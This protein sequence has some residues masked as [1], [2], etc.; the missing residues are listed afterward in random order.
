MGEQ[1]APGTGAR[2]RHIAN[3]YEIVGLDQDT[4]NDFDGMSVMR[5][6]RGTVDQMIHGIVTALNDVL[7]PM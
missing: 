1:K 2:R 3:I 5:A 7:C 4:Y 6:G